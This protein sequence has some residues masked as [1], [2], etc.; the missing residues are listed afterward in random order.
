M[1]LHVFIIFFF[2]SPESNELRQEFEYCVDNLNETLSEKARWVL[3]IWLFITPIVCV[4]KVLR[5]LI[6]LFP[7]HLRP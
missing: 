1:Y 3:F 5:I 7:V 6:G 2:L 4:R